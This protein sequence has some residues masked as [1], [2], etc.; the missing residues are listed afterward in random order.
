M[1]LACLA[2]KSPSREIRLFVR[3]WDGRV[4]GCARV[5]CGRVVGAGVQVAWSDGLD[6]D[7]IPRFGGHI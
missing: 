5:G 7:G 6:R 4:C 1:G 2:A 3:A